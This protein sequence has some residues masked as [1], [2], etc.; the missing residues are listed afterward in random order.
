MDYT[1][2]VNAL[3][4]HTTTILI[5]LDETVLCFDYWIY[6]PT[7]RPRTNP[8]PPNYFAHPAVTTLSYAVALPLYY[9]AMLWLAMPPVAIVIPLV[10]AHM[11]LAELASQMLWR[12]A[13][14]ELLTAP[15]ETTSDATM[16]PSQVTNEG[17]PSSKPVLSTADRLFGMYLPVQTAALKN[18][19]LLLFA[20]SLAAQSMA[21]VAFGAFMEQFLNC[22]A[23]TVCFFSIYATRDYGAQTHRR[24]FSHTLKWDR[25]TLVQGSYLALL[26]LVRSGMRWMLAVEI[27]PL[28]DIYNEV[29]A[30]ELYSVKRF[31]WF[32]RWYNTQPTWVKLA[33]AG[34]G[35]AVQLGAARYQQRELKQNNQKLE[36]LAAARL[37]NGAGKVAPESVIS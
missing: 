37:E 3:L 1:A 28:L 22:L 33:C 4:R 8:W 35:I 25:Y 29:R 34:L 16:T 5:L 9:K 30:N 32:T 36:R 26:W 21:T 10:A 31:G 17:A 12:G 18:A 6:T 24:H 11:S 20:H 23:M 7:I 19:S 27:L 15:P 13:V 14:E 2:L